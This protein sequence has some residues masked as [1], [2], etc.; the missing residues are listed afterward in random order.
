[1]VKFID[2]AYLHTMS[3]LQQAIINVFSVAALHIKPPQWSPRP[4]N[5]HLPNTIKMFVTA[6]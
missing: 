6:L 5:V 4:P 3:L 2:A 1:M